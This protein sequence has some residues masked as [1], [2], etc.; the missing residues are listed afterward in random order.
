M[1]NKPNL[2]IYE[3]NCK[4]DAFDYYIAFQWII[5]S[6]RWM[7]FRITNQP[8]NTETP[9]WPL[10]VME[11]LNFTIQT[12]RFRKCHR[13]LVLVVS[14][15]KLA[16][17]GAWSCGFYHAESTTTENHA[18]RTDWFPRFVSVCEGSRPLEVISKLAPHLWS[19]PRGASDTPFHRRYS[20]HSAHAITHCGMLAR[21]IR[22][23]TVFCLW[24]WQTKFLVIYC[25]DYF[26]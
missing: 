9:Q 4:Q 20:F 24:L 19:F 8:Q 17:D 3:S 11:L 6:N 13:L 5:E 12:K 25:N 26:S 14:K 15:P 10:I 7:E 22:S 18:A 1:V 16:F 2:H 21:N 23:V